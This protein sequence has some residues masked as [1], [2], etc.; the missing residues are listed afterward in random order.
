MSPLARF[1]TIALA[2]LL[3]AMPSL[4][5]AQNKDAPA[6]QGISRLG[7]AEGWSAYSDTE[8]NRKTCYLIGEPSK[9]EPAGAKRDKA[10]VTVTHRPQEKATN[11]VSFKA[12]Y[13]FKEG[14]DAEL[15]VDG[16]KFSLFTNKDAA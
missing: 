12:G 3:A 5:V 11:E 4:A 1:A 10:Q 7:S 8:K 15:A 9:S 2:A 16:K 13:V 6:E 14:S